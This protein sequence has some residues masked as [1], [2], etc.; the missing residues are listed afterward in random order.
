MLLRSKI[1][2]W[3]VLATFLLAALAGGCRGAGAAEPGEEAV[4]PAPLENYRPPRGSS[5]EGREIVV[6]VR[7]RGPRTVLLLATIH[8]DEAAGTPLLRALVE[9]MDEDPPWLA[10]CRA[11]VI[12]VANPDGL[13]RGARYNSH[14]VDLNRNFPASNRGEDRRFGPFALSEPEARFLCGLVA[15]YQ[16]DRIL[17]FHQPIGLIDWDGPA[18]ELARELAAVSPLPARRYGS[19]PGSLGSWAGEDLRIPIVTVELRR[20]DDLLDDEEAWREHGA[21]LRRFLRFD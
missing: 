5:V 17:S 18:E 12:P 14:G 9:R 10:G 11:V 19:M 20:S 16:P 8:G 1:H 3:A 21:M 4:A 15:T 6:L 13:A 7:G 2:P